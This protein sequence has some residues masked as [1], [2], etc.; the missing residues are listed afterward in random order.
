MLVAKR[1][2]PG[3]SKGMTT[4][5]IRNC[6]A[7]YQE[8]HGVNKATLDN[9]RRNLSSFFRWLEDENYIFK[10]PLRRIHKIK[11]TVSV[12]PAVL[13]VEKP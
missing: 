9:V 7:Q 2:T 8:E 11:T 12:H 5:D 3:H 6:L 13:A 10:S 1:T 4:D